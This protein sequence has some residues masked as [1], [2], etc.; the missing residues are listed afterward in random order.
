MVVKGTTGL[1]VGVSLQN[2]VQCGLQDWHQE[3]EGVVAG[4]QVVEAELEG[5]AELKGMVEMLDVDV[6]VVVEELD[7]MDVDVDVE[8]VYVVMEQMEVTGVQLVMEMLE[9]PRGSV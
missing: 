3:G 6:V 7:G 4:L 1:T 8:M 9:M 2:N 5:L